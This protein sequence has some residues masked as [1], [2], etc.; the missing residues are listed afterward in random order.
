[1]HQQPLATCTLAASG[2]CIARMRVA[3]YRGPASRL[4]GPGC[5]LRRWN[6]SSHKPVEADQAVRDH[7]FMVRARKAWRMTEVLKRAV[8]LAILGLV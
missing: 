1:M 3:V 5:G 8:V 7:M 2:D 6:K 4:H